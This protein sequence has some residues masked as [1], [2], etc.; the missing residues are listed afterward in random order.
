MQYHIRPVEVNDAEKLVAYMRALT[1]EPNI[2]LP[3]TPGE[4]KMTVEE[5]RAFLT[6]YLDDPRSCWLVATLGD[7]IVAS[8]EMTTYS[9]SGL[10]HMSVLGMSVGSA[11]RGKGLGD[12]LLGELLDWARNEG[13]IKRIELWV[14]ARNLPAINLYL[15]HGFKFEGKRTAAIIKDGQYLDDYLMGLILQ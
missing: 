11:H 15:K 12:K 6:K 5:E 4:F 1:S 10:R 13:G 3:W 9:R 14:F 7:E 8:T 2:N